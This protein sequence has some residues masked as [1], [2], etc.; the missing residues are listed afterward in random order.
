MSVYVN[1]TLRHPFQF[2]FRDQ[3][4]SQIALLRGPVKGVREGFM[5]Y[6]N[7][8]PEELSTH[9]D[10]FCKSL[11]GMGLAAWLFHYY[12]YLLACEY[13]MLYLY[14]GLPDSSFTNRI[15]DADRVFAMI[16]DRFYSNYGQKPEIYEQHFKQAGIQNAMHSVLNSPSAI[17]G[18]RSMVN[19]LAA[20]N[21][22]AGQRYADFLQKESVVD[23]MT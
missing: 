1:Y 15:E 10:N 19:I 7:R 14:R 3:L 12:D 6:H 16:F 9:I 5:Y 11:E 13:A 2:Y 22:D 20:I 23:I 18:L 4:L 8:T 17:V 21:P